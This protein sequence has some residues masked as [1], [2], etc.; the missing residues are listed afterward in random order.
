MSSEK[1]RLGEVRADKEH[2]ISCPYIDNIVKKVDLLI[3]FPQY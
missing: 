1:I 2:N 3:L